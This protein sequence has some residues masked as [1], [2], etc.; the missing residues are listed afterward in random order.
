[1]FISNINYNKH[2]IVVFYLYLYNLL[3]NTAFSGQAVKCEHP[4]E[5]SKKLLSLANFGTGRF[6]CRYNYNRK[7]VLLQSSALPIIVLNFF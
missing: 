1:M 7:Q 2:C 4:I 3:T 5:A 6:D